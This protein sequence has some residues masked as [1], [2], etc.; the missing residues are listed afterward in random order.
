[1]AAQA[2]AST[3]GASE[4]NFSN[5]NA[6]GTWRMA[7]NYGS[8]GVDRTQPNIFDAMGRTVDVNQA[9][10]LEIG[11]DSQGMLK[12]L[13]TEPSA[14]DRYDSA[15]DRVN[16]YMSTFK[17]T[18]GQNHR[19][20]GVGGVMSADKILD[21]YIIHTHSTYASS[22]Q[23][24]RLK[25]LQAQ[26]NRDIVSTQRT[27]LSAF[28]TRLFQDMNRIRSSGLSEYFSQLFR[29]LS[30]DNRPFAFGLFFV[31]VCLLSI[32]MS[33]INTITLRV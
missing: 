18:G 16:L 29:I 5:T 25:H 31:F 7:D 32:A 4:I 6:D 8:V 28:L 13:G 21:L 33:R 22:V 12:N 26:A 20:N 23:D 24:A 11:A 30:S 2:Q 15:A 3:S 9:L 1:M 19:K 27:G 14:I 10:Q 17:T